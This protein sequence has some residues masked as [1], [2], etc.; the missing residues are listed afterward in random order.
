[1]EPMIS[2]EVPTRPWSVIEA[3]LASYQGKTY[4]VIQDYYSKYPEIKKLRRITSA[5]V[6]KSLKKVFSQHGIPDILRSDN[7]RQFTSYE[8]QEF[9]KT[10]GFKWISSSPEYQQSNGQAESAVKLLKQILK[11]NPEDFDLALLAY[12]NTV[13][14]CGA[15]PAQLLYGRALKD[16]TPSLKQKLLPKLPD[17]NEIREKM[18]EEKRKQKRNYDDRHRVKEKQEMSKEDKAV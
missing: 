14:S 17:H 13:L 16:R 11:K 8:F 10:Y 1:M 3:D 9:A 5:A 12:R 15:S 4:L 18:L 7:G 6:I 2:S